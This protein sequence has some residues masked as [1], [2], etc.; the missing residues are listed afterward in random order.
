MVNYGKVYSN[1]EELNH[2]LRLFHESYEI[3]SKHNSD[4]N[5]SYTMELNQFADM[6][7]QEIKAKYL[8]GD[9]DENYLKSIDTEPRATAEQAGASLFAQERVQGTPS[10][11]D[12]RTSGYIPKKVLNQGACGSCWAFSISSMSEVSYNIKKGL[13]GSS[14]KQFSPQQILDCSGGGSCSGGTVSNGVKY[15]WTKGG[16][17]LSQYPYKAS[18]GSCRTFSTAAYM[19]T[20]SKSGYISK[21]ESNFEKYSAYRVLSVV[22]AVNKNFMRYSKGVF[23]DSQCETTKS[24]LHGVDLVGYSKSGKYWILKNSWGSKWGE[25]GY[26]KFKKDS[27]GTC[28]MYKW[29]FYV[30]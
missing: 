10:S 26:F 15:M 1:P 27:I 17:S 16:I 18:K 14:A 22:I 3:V 23:S 11:V 20:N 2:R 7:E 29:G 13:K 30:D 4:P 6:D 5:A 12:W 9:Y 24:G 28:G 19:R 21:T 8:M 25:K